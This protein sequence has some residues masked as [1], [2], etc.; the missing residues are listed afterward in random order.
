MCASLSD[1]ICKFTVYARMRIGGGIATP[2][3]GRTSLKTGF[4]GV[5]KLVLSDVYENIINLR[6]MLL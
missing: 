5:V 4:T 1:V 2:K 3:R 6:G